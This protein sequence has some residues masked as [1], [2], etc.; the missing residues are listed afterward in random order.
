MI[1]DLRSQKSGPTAGERADLQLVRKSSATSRQELVPTEEQTTRSMSPTEEYTNKVA[2]VP[3]TMQH[4]VPVIQ[5]AQK[6]RQM[7][8]AQKVQKAATIPQVQYSVRDRGY[9]CATV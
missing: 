1:Q 7:P 8:V 4:Q 9:P 3:I 6:R 5:T 2:A